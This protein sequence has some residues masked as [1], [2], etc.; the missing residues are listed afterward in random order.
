MTKQK[1]VV[2]TLFLALVSLP[3]QASI[4]GNSNI[5]PVAQSVLLNATKANQIEMIQVKMHIKALSRVIILLGKELAKPSSDGQNKFSN[6]SD[7]NG[8]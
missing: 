7:L 5:R 2:N 6:K 4:E 3:L 8:R 1:R